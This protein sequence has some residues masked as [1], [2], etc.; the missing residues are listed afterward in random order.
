MFDKIENFI[1]AR[2]ALKI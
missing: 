1:E 2:Y